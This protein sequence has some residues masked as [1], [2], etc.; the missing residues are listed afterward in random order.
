M[1]NQE[2]HIPILTLIRGIPGSGKSTKAKSIGCFHVEADMFHMK[3]GAYVYDSA[4]AKSAHGFCFG[5]VNQV[6]CRGVDVVV[7]NTFIT[8]GSVQQYA[9]MAE[10]H[11]YVFRVIRM[12]TRYETTHAVPKNVITK[13]ESSFE[14]YSGESIINQF[15][16]KP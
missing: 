7:S 11:G 16:E 6:M 1:L 5:M 8:K 3:D 10:Y 13:M 9:N 2:K 12:E 15:K 4:L 14:N